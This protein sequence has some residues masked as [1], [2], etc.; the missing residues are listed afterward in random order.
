MYN[1]HTKESEDVLVDVLTTDGQQTQ[2]IVLNDDYN[3]FDWV[4]E[5]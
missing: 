3:T 5:S 4:I 2:L 1:N